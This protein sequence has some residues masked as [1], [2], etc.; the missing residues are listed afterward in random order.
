[1]RSVFRYIIGDS[2]IYAKVMQE[3][4]EAVESGA[5]Q[6]PI[7]YA[8]A[9]KLEYFQACLKE[10]LRYHPAIPW[11]L[12]RTVPAGGAHIAGHFFPAGTEVAMSPFVWHRQTAAFG[13]DARVFRPERW[14]EADVAQ[15][16]D[17][18]HNL[19]TFGS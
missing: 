16:R 15:R 18:E 13:E 17:M 5:L 6:F 12:P 11:S 9:T 8:D 7:T 2:R 1:M 4:D 3:I 19:I 14:I 10:T